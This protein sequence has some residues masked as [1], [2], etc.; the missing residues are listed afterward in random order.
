M[1][2]AKKIVQVGVALANGQ[3]WNAFHNC[4]IATQTPPSAIQQELKK[5][6]SEGQK[7]LSEVRRVAGDI[8]SQASHVKRV[9]ESL[10]TFDASTTTLFLLVYAV[11]VCL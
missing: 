11:I 7:E 10:K 9:G 2:E 5:D 1:T 6:R 4:P 8:Q 3:L